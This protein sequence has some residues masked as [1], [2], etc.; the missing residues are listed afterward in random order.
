MAGRARS[1]RARFGV[2]LASSS[3]AAL[4]VG[5]GAPAAFAQCAISPG[6]NQSSVSN[7]A[8][9]NCINING[10]TVTGNVTNTGPPNSGV[11]TATGTSAPT[12]TGITINNASVGGAIV[13]AG[14]ITSSTSGKGIFVTNNATV[15]GGISNSG[16]ISAGRTGIF[17]DNVS[18]FSGGISNSGTISA[19]A[20]GIA[21][22]EETTQVSTFLGGVSNSGMITAHTGILVG[23]GVT[24]FFGGISNSGTIVANSRGI[25][26]N[27]TPSTLV[28]SFT[29][30]ISNS[31][32]IS[33]GRTGIFVDNVSTFSRGITNSGTISAGEIGIAIANTPPEISTFLG[34]V[35]NSGLI[36]AGTG[37]LVGQGVSSFFGGITNS[38]TIS[39]LIAGHGIYV[40]GVS[41]FMGPIANSGLIIS[42][43]E[44]GIEVVA[45]STFSGGISNGGTISASGE[46]G[47]GIYVD[48]VSNFSGGISN[49]GIIT[50]RNVGIEIGTEAGSVSTFSGGVTNTGTISAATGIFV[51][52]SGPVSIF[53][54]GT[55]IGTGGTAV[56]LTHNAPG[57]TFTLGPGYSITGNVLGHSGGGDTFQ[58][59]G[60][61]YGSFDLSWIGPSQRYQ[62]FTTFNVVGG[63]WNTSGTFD[64]ATPLTWSVE[65]G[66]LAGA[67]TFGTSLNPVSIVVANGG[68][69]EPGGAAM[70][71]TPYG[72][73]GTSMTITGN[74]TFN[75]QSSYWVNLNPTTASYA[76]VTGTASLNG[77]VLGYLTPGSYSGG[78]NGTKYVILDAGAIAPGTSFAGFESL[79]APGFTGTLTGVGDPQIQL[80]LVSSLSGTNQN[81]SNVANAINSYFN[82]GGTL[83]ADFFPVFGANPGSLLSQLSGEAGTGAEQASIQMTNEFLQLMLDPFV[84]GRGNAPGGAGGGGGPA[85]GFAP[86]QQASLP[87]DIA[88]AYAEVLKA[89]AP[90]HP[91]PAS[92]GGSGWGFA[93]R[94]GAWGTAYGGANNTEG[95]ATAGSHDLSAQTYGFAAGMDYRFAPYGVAGFAL[96]GGGTNWGLSD[97]LGSG[98]SQ[99][100]QFGGYGIEWFGPAYV[101]GALSFTNNWFTTNRTALGDQLRANFVGQSYGARFEGGYRFTPSLP[102]PVSGGGLGWGLGVTPYG[103]LQF[104]D[105]STPAYSESDL[106]GGGFGL[107]YAAMNATDI[108]TELGA[109]F[110]NPT[111][112]YGKPLILFGRLAW[113][114]D[115]VSN[116]SLSAAFEALPGTSFTVFGAPIPHDSAL[117]TAGA[118]YFLTAN[119]QV[120]AKFD[121]EFAPGAQT[122]A[123]TGTLRY[124]W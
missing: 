50:A 114:H 102:S 1:R 16:T 35:S 104:Q 6:T 85:L 45:V 92:G 103:A 108:R 68:T 40:Y 73:P 8:A 111:L 34:G 20:I 72:S 52:G 118:Q 96:A 115:F 63:V 93:Q 90:S 31:G 26:V 119:W 69:L 53:D 47:N 82:N 21:I 28:G 29:G 58:L 41:V 4:L 84:N 74:L 89:P 13:N 65:G 81:Q 121:G 97:A 113:A 55:I 33:A 61:G 15:S 80:Q 67:S 99:A 14:Q 109:R 110:D 101:A 37:I 32:M 66:T 27:G 123:G 71:G 7:S 100:F 46:F 60:S 11:I 122:Y 87:P 12:R 49:S 112:L 48:N 76:N 77:T 54:S 105:F 88:L 36:T 57:N 116:P 9:I 30:G 51:A 64:I 18:T 19:G 42:R 24:S 17:V 107:S 83:P 56:D 44:N 23:P 79:N 25:I 38:G 10:I 43:G 94:W 70:P 75:P 106:T 95:N 62:N 117:T 86:D 120:I 5:S 59:G 98:Y 78:P 22:A 91:S 124:T 2:L 3:V 39:D